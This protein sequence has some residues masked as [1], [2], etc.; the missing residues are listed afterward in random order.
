MGAKGATMQ[1]TSVRR[2]LLCGV[3]GVIS[4]WASSALAQEHVFDVPSELAIRA[5]P[6]FGRQAGLQIVVPAAALSGVI[7]PAIKGT[8]DTRAALRRLLEGL[9]VEIASD[10]GQTIILRVPSKNAEAAS[11]DGAANL[12]PLETVTV[13]GTHIR[14]AS[15]TSPV[16]T[17]DRGYIDTS[18]YTSTGDVL[19]SLP[20]NYG[21]GLNSTV[22]SPD[23]AISGATTANLR[24]LGSESTLT[25]IDGHRLADAEA[26]SAI[27]VNII[28]LAAIDRIEVLTD[29]ASAVYGSDAVGGVVNF[30]LKK[31]FDG[32][33]TSAT[34]GDSTDGGGFQQLYDVVAGKVW[35]TGHATASYEFSGQDSVLGSQR[36]F[37]S[38]DVANTTLVPKTRR[39]SGFVDAEQE[40]LP[41][42]SIFVE[43]LYTDRSYDAVYDFDAFLPG[44]ASENYS[45]VSQYGV[46]GGLN[47]QF[48]DWHVSLTGDIAGDRSAAVEPVTIDGSL[49]QTTVEN[50]STG[51]GSAE[52]SADG[53]IFQ[54]SSGPVSLAFGGSY[55][56]ESFRDNTFAGE[57][58]FTNVS[59]NRSITSVYGELNFPVVSPSSDREGLHSLV[60]TAAG[61]FDDYSDFGTSVIPKVGINYIPMSDVSIKASWGESFRAPSLYQEYQGQSA[62][63]QPYPD[64][65]SPQGA[66]TLL[67]LTGGN[68][69][70]GPEK[71]QDTTLNFTY[72]PSWLSGARLEATYFNIAYKDRI[73]MPTEQTDTPLEQPGIGPFLTPNPSAAQ[74]AAVL[75]VS[76]FQNNTANPYDPANVVYLVDDRTTNLASENAR[77]LDIL[78]DYKVESD[79]GVF[80][81]N[82]N[83]TYLNFK[84]RLTPESSVQPLSGIV[85]NPPTVRGRAGLSWGYDNWTSSLFVNYNGPTNDP[86]LTARQ[87]IGSWTTVDLQIAYSFAADTDL[88][89]IRVAVS[90][91]NILDQSPPYVANTGGDPGLNYD[92]TNASPLG[93]FISVRL[94]KDW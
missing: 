64:A 10:D 50:F 52:F 87:L 93:R 51:L 81:F 82:L 88:S 25:L 38:P 5:I 92:S 40:I 14:G 45:R 28:P 43:G 34:L 18:G 33:Q 19:R 11:N 60:V 26:Q 77:G 31:D 86:S 84:E 90:A 73:A 54:L 49:I 48:G 44:F 1:R 89:G 12:L 46:T 68:P 61:R 2:R 74:L 9:N 23:L 4:L 80:D 29:G 17:L 6:E 59:V 83:A 35:D 8:F 55:R 15:P 78:A 71:S 79:V 85:F 94:A 41:N 30:I 37:T 39:N 65:N 76:S 24:G 58:V 57:T 62:Y 53:P 91:L 69:N 3:A 32:A 72:T 67:L 20:Q 21:G 16:L 7:T 56:R 66:S 75:A 63:L 13:T 36:S 47:A 27:D 42:V 22:G 70:L